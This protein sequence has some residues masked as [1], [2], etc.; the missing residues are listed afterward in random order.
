M[1]FKCPSCS[2]TLQV[3]PEMAGRTVR[4]PGC[5]TKVQI[6]G[7]PS[8]PSA[9][10][11]ADS[12]PWDNVK[13]HDVAPDQTSAS[14]MEDSSDTTHY[15]PVRTGW[16]E[17]DPTNPNSFLAFGL[18]LVSAVALLAALYAF[19]PPAAKA[20]ADYNSMEWLASLFFKHA[21]ISVTNTIFFCWAIAILY[22]KMAKLRQQKF[23]LLL[24]VLP[25]ELGDE[26]NSQNVGLFIDHL[27]SFP[28]RVRDSMMVNR[29]RKGLELFEVRPSVDRVSQMLSSQ[30][31]IDSIRIGASFTLC[32]AF[33]WAIPIL[34]FIGT[35]I[36]LSHAIGGMNFGNSEDIKAVIGMLQ[37]VVGGLGT[38]FD[39][40]LLGLVLALL[41]NFPM[42]SMIKAEDDNLNAIDAFCNEILLPR[43]ND[44]GESNDSLVN[45]LGSETGAFIAALSQALAG[46]QKEFLADLKAVTAKI[47]EQATNLD[48]RADAH[49]VTV[50]TEFSKTMIKLRE[51]VTT[52]ISDS[53]VRT[54]DYVRTLASGLQ[55]LNNVLTQLGQQQVLIQQVKKK[56]WFS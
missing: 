24:D 39:A 15:K 52:S 10:A 3:E 55:G 4:C 33:L 44:G 56:G 43:L 13:D 28:H 49:A 8:I 16:V 5:T 7:A 46:A 35:V 45:A 30:S 26:I 51:D 14:E 54:G 6:P 36:G 20:A 18:G 11:A 48:R 19:N 32:K 47:Q 41:V 37:N 17:T 50:A 27:Y 42:N 9:P 2:M 38:A 34:G 1:K 29:I 40:T 22:L 21:L 23:A 12:S 53:A 25:S 31:D